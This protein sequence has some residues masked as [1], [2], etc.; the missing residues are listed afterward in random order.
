MTAKGGGQGHPEAW[1]EKTEAEG[2]KSSQLRKRKRVGDD[3]SGGRNYNGGAKG[4]KTV[5]V[6]QIGLHFPAPV[7]A[8][9]SPPRNR[10]LI[11]WVGGWVGGRVGQNPREARMA[12]P[13]TVSLANPL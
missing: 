9:I 8:F 10:F 1:R 4:N 7:V 11:W 6:P 12:P 2:V 13:V 3:S 5:C